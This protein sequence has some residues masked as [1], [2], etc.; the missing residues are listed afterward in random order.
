MAFYGG[1]VTC[2]ACGLA[3]PSGKVHTIDV[4]IAY[5]DGKPLGPAWPSMVK[6]N[7]DDLPEPP[8]PRRRDERSE[9]EFWLG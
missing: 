1:F 4:C 9:E 2:Q 3:T 6:Y 5:Q 7:I 8:P